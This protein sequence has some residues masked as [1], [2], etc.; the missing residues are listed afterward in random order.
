MIEPQ[1]HVVVFDVNVYLDVADRVGPPFTWEKF[2]SLELLQPGTRRPTQLIVSTT[3]FEL[4]H[5]AR[6]GDSLAL[7]CSKSGPTAT[8]TR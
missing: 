7:S 1:L 6:V 4:S 8:S 5:P 3:P 2:D